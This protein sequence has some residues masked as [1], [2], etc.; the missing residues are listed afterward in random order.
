M[1]MLNTFM[2]RVEAN[3]AQNQ[4]KITTQKKTKLIQKDGELEKDE[5][6]IHLFHYTIECL[7]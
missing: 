3:R 4:S 6:S 1:S 7:E 2:H 5:Y